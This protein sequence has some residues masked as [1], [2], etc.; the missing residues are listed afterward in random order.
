MKQA[1]GEFEV[2]LLPQ[3]DERAIP[4]FGRMTIDKV[5]RGDLE[6]TSQGQMISTGTTVSNSAGYVAIERV[7][8]RLNGKKGAFALQHNAIMN[9][10]EG[11]LNV[12]VVPDSG[13]DELTG[14]TG[15]LNII[16]KD[17]KHFYEFDYELP[18]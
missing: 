12:I 14:L 7:E 6:G 2:K 3:T 4:L 17:G 8:G 10:G 13:T 16:R 11:S 9:K 15:K 5:F 18:A 1:K